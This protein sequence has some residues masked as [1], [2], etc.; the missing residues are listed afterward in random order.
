MKNQTGYKTTL[1][2]GC[3]TVLLA[4]IFIPI[5]SF[6]SRGEPV[7]QLAAGDKTDFATFGW[8]AD[9]DGDVLVV[10]APFFR[11][12]PAD[13]GAAYIFRRTG[14]NWIQE[15][16]LVPSISE[17]GDHFGFSVAISGDTIFVGQPYHPSI[18]ASGRVFVFQFNGLTWMEQQV[19]GPVA[20][21]FGY[22]VAL[23]D[24]TAAVV[25]ETSSRAYVYTRVAQNWSLVQTLNLPP[26]GIAGA[27][28]SVGLHGNRLV[29][30]GLSP[31]AFIFSRDGSIWSHE[32][33]LSASGVTFGGAAS[34]DESFVLLGA[35][36]ENNSHGA[37]Y[38]FARAGS[39]WTFTQRVVSPTQT[40]A[41]TFGFSVSI[42]DDLVAIGS[43]GDRG[44]RGS[45][46]IYRRCGE[47]W[48]PEQFIIGSTTIG[49]SN[50][51]W[52]TVLNGG[53]VLVG[54]PNENVFSFNHSGA[55]YLT[56]AAADCDADS[57]ADGCELL[58]GAPD[59][60]LNII[61][62]EC[63]AASDCNQNGSQDIC[64]LAAH[65]SPDCNQNEIPDE[66]DILSGLSQDAD[67]DGVPDECYS[68]LCE[69]P[70]AGLVFC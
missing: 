60:N 9:L 68:V 30:A 53:L 29:L 40:D 31:H 35:G 19:L 33:T 27:T 7:V 28:P 64:D 2:R 66:C 22:A 6:T 56:S 15:Q 12:S 26:G 44:L 50:F 24:D 20:E 41:A 59:C 67:G 52:Q 55:V 3:W 51:G 8:S 47:I 46:W 63:E 58:E 39:V 10:G 21:H 36:H 17:P 14:G 4:G 65:T 18:F 54:A 13:P 25:G 42:E 61:L 5:L 1:L 70:S 69:D 11:E 34:I 45:A 57:Q 37:A 16:R 49:N 62:D 48:T 23:E 32:Q 43:P 38:I